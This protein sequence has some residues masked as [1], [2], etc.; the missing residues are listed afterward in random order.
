METTQGY[1]AAAMPMPVSE[2]ESS[3]HRS[4][5][6]VGGATNGTENSTAEG[7]NAPERRKR[8]RMML[9]VAYDGTKYHGSFSIP[10][11]SVNS[12]CFKWVTVKKR[13][14]LCIDNV[15]HEQLLIK[16]YGKL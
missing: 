7:A 16:D 8:R 9:V 2:E 12:T 5:E 1:S 11:S 15:V 3:Q 6:D 10:H 14:Y 4:Q 13:E